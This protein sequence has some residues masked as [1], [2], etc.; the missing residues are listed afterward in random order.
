MQKV[1]ELSYHENHEN[2]DN[3]SCSVV[4]QELG[5]LQ[6]WVGLLR[7]IPKSQW[8]RS[9]IRRRPSAVIHL[10]S[11]LSLPRQEVLTA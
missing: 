5:T 11:L 6:R 3:I 4:V 9:T 1:D 2:H 7:I 8:P 10:P